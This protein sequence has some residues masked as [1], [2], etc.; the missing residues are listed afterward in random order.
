MLTQVGRV[1]IKKAQGKDEI[2]SN[3]RWKDHLETLRKAERL[4]GGRCEEMNAPG[5]TLIQEVDSS[6][7]H[8]HPAPPSR[9]LE[10]DMKVN[11]KRQ[12]GFGI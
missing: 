9:R 7:K 1:L 11:E 4:R 12:S 2:V 5:D 6:G 8:V 3:A 10:N